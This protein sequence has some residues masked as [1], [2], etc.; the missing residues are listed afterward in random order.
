MFTKSSQN[1]NKSSCW[2]FAIVAVIE[3]YY[4]IRGY[5][6]TPFSEQQ[7]VDCSESDNGCVGG[8]PYTGNML[9]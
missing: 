5:P 6:L 1:F 4:A 2:A 8:N 7:L 3:S 9:Y